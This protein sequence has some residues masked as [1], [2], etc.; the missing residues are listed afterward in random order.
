MTTGG[1]AMDTTTAVRP[2]W[3]LSPVDYRAY[4]LPDDGSD[5]P[6]PVVSAP[7]GP[8][9]AVAGADPA[10]CGVSALRGGLLAAAAVAPDYAYT[11][12]LTARS[13]RYTALCGHQVPSVA[14]VCPPGPDCAGCAAAAGAPLPS[15]RH[16]RPTR[17]G[18]RRG[19]AW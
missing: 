17:R 15:G 8:P 11:A 7:C 5:E 19:G 12:G 18:R 3:V 9:V 14:M 16:R 2:R 1:E 13:G 6:V 10:W 4:A